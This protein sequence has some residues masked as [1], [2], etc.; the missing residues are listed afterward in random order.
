MIIFVKYCKQKA[1]RIQIRQTENI[2]RHYQDCKLVD[3]Y[4]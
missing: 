2:F 4:E 3:K 1:L